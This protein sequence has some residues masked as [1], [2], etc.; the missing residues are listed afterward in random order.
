MLI[1][2]IIKWD[3]AMKHDS[4]IPHRIFDLPTDLTKL[5]TETRLAAPDYPNLPLYFVAPIEVLSIRTFMETRSY[6]F[7]GLMD[8]MRHFCHFNQFVGAMA[9]GKSTKLRGDRVLPERAGRIV[10]F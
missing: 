9:A 4:F 7:E 5:T 2:E 6:L 1:E 3:N 10:R 8:I